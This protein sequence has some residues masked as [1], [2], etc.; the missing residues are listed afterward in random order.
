MESPKDLV[1]IGQRVRELRQLGHLS[2]Q[3]LAMAS[4]L[5]QSWLSRIERGTIEDPSLPATRRLVR[6]LGISLDDL[7]CSAERWEEIRRDAATRL[8]RIQI[9]PIQ[10]WMDLP[11]YMRAAIQASPHVLITGSMGCGKTTMLR[12]ILAGLEPTCMHLLIDNA[13]WRASDLSPAPTPAAWLTLAQAQA[14]GYTLVEDLG[15]DAQ[16]ITL[17]DLAEAQSAYC[18][19]ASEVHDANV[20]AAPPRMLLATMHAG[21]PANTVARIRV[22]HLMAHPNENG[23]PAKWLERTPLIVHMDRKLPGTRVEGLYQVFPSLTPGKA[24]FHKVDEDNFI[25]PPGSGISAA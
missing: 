5:E 25:L 23:L 10:L 20:F 9:D 4:G 1:I 17:M 21:D 7:F 11:Q 13:L 8:A 16:R 6:V 12:A 24:S 22:N 3:Q 18:V 2:Q 14:R 15:V 19:V